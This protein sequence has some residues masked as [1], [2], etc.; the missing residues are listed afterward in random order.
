MIYLGSE[1]TVTQDYN[2][3]KVAEDYAGVFKSVIKINGTG[4]VIKII[5]KFISHEDSI[6]YNEFLSN[7]K[8][9]YSNGIYKCVSITG[10]TV[11][12][13]A[14]EVG[15]NQI[16]IETYDGTKKIILRLCHLDDIFVKVN[17]IVS[18]D[19]ILAYQGNTGL[20][21]SGKDIDDITYG[22]HVHLEATDN[23]NNI[24]PRK[25]AIGEVTTTYISGSNLEN[26]KNNQIKILVNLINIRQ[27]PDELSLDVGNVYYNEFY[28]VLDVIVKTNYTWYKIITNDKILGYVAN[29]VTDNWVKYLPKEEI[30]SPYKLIYTCKKTGKYLIKLNASEKLYITKS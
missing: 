30:I 19:T 22:T 2:T 12:M 13:A 21:L 29:K 9:W 23:G 20:V 5:N 1:R 25:Y 6:N 7:Q 18:K 17:D 26:K 15:G 4:K 11:N 28:D 8:N 27:N 14:E 24:N 3:H 16:W 10:K